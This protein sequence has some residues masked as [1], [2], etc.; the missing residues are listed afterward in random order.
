VQS[1]NAIYKAHD[2]S[3]DYRRVVEA[4]LGRGLDENESVIVRAFG[5]NI[6]QPAPTGKDRDE[7]F[8]RLRARIDE[9][10]QR[11]DGVPEEEIDAAIDE[12]ADY[13]RHHRG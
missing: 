11:A 10:A 13:V 4:L 7:A 6:V 3:P 9:T 12:A 2:L 5:G 8:R 1:V